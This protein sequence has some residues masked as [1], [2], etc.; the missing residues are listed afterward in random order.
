MYKVERTSHIDV[1]MS[2]RMYGGVCV[3]GCGG[4]AL[5]WRQVMLGVCGGV[6]PHGALCWAQ[7]P[8]SPSGTLSHRG[9]GWCPG[10][11]HGLQDGTQWGA[12]AELGQTL[13]ATVGAPPPPSGCSST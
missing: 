11:L 6:V 8:V 12:A 2:V 5:A 4:E 10:A 9:Q 13:S 1:G 7:E 3:F